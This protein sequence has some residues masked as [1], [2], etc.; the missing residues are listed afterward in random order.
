MEG[1]NDAHRVFPSVEPGNL[2]HQRTIRRNFVVA[3]KFAYLP[4]GQLAVLRGERIDRRGDELLVDPNILAIFGE[5]EDSGV[6]L[7]D[8]TTQISP[9]LGVRRRKIDVT[10]PE[11]R[12]FPIGKMRDQRQRLRI[13]HNDRV[14]IVKM[15]PHGVLEHNLFVDRPFGFRKL[16]ALALQ[17]IVKLLGAAKEA[18]RSLNQVPVGVNACRVHHQG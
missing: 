6:I 13:V 4:V 5:R 15:K 11:P 3:Q 2:R 10:L 7:L 18:R 1:L 8:E 12:D 14:A 17:R 16:Q 9:Y